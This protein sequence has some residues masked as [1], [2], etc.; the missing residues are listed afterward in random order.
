MDIEFSEVVGADKYE[1]EIVDYYG[2]MVRLEV[3]APANRAEWY[4]PVNLYRVRVR[5]IN[6]GGFGNWSEDVIHAL[7]AATEPRQEEPPVEPPPIEPPPIEPPPGPQ[8][9]IFCF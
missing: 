3:P 8:C 1:I 9:M 4:G 6:C 2:V 7:N 5:T